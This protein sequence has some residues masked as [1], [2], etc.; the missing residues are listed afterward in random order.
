MT[1]ACINALAKASKEAQLFLTGKAKIDFEK[2][3]LLA[4]SVC[5]VTTVHKKVRRSHGYY[6]TTIRVCKDCG[7]EV[8][9]RVDKRS[10]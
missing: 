8:D 6:F 1:D 9:F 7:N 5:K 3:C 2:E 4:C 10:R